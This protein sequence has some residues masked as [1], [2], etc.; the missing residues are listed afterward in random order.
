MVLTASL[1]SLAFRTFAGTIL[2]KFGTLICIYQTATLKVDNFIMPNFIY[3]SMG[4][5]K[6]VN[7]V[8]NIEIATISFYPMFTELFDWCKN[9]VDSSYIDTMHIMISMSYT[10]AI[11]AS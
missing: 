8:M 2:T 9:I 1:A 3:T 11:E 10:I 5:Y 7:D 6:N 4:L